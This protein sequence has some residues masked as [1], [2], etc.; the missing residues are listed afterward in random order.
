MVFWLD[1]QKVQSFN[2]CLTKIFKKIYILCLKS[3]DQILAR[4]IFNPYTQFF[5]KSRDIVFWVKSQL[6]HYY[7]IS[8][9]LYTMYFIKIFNPPTSI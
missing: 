3:P 1:E 9:F 8:Q 4:C 5:K 7:A 6:K 2:D